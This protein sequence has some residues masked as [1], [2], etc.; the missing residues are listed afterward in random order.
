[1]PAT[2]I[3]ASILAVFASPQGG[4]PISVES[5]LD[6]V[7][8]YTDQAMAERVLQVTAT[9]PGAVTV[10]VGPLPM[11]ADRE[12]FQTRVQGASAVLQGLEVRQRT[13]ELQQS[14][15]DQ[16]RLQIAA[17]QADL[18]ALDAER[19]AIVAGQGMLE[20]VVNSVGKEGLTGY[21][22]MTL[23]N[24]FRFVTAETAKLDAREQIYERERDALQV[25]IRDLEQQLGGRVRAARPYQEVDLRLFFQQAGTAEVRLLYLVRGTS[26]EPV[27]DLRLSTDLTGVDVG[28]VGRI[29][30][31]TDEDWQ[32]VQV[33]LST[34][35]PQL[36]LDP[37]ELPRRWA[38]VYQ[39]ERW[40]R[41]AVTANAAPAADMAALESL[42]YLDAEGEV[43][44]KRGRDDFGGFV[45]APTVSVQD[46]GL[47]QQFAL[48]DRVSLK[49]GTEPRQFRLVDVPLEVRPERYIVPSLS[50][51]AYLRAEV[52]SEAEAPLLPGS[53]RVFLGPDY[54]GESSFP[55]LRQGDSTLLNLGIDP[56]L[57]VEYEV[58]LDE[59]DEPGLFSSELR[60]N[61][62]YEVRLKLSASARESI[63]VLIEEVLPVPQDD[64]IKISPYKMAAGAL[65]TP[66]DL[67]D[68][69]EKGVWRWRMTMR[70]GQETALRWGYTAAF[71]EKYTPVID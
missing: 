54:I 26:W 18:R 30:Q 6:R 8:V 63:D 67:K 61:H 49:S 59:R 14:E 32:D 12:S 7:T 29:Y 24:V 17:V 16:L 3:L 60:H 10:R 40:A 33:L 69:E 64:R 9:E 28:L 35:Q 1:M 5:Q 51:Q 25:Q 71:N 62:W 2:A 57:V 48:P 70:P 46:Y 52:T 13:G 11:T 65:D 42:G 22:G 43:A 4:E 36:G 27:Y 19:R 15:R 23:E 39:P 56:N 37:P 50:Q 45:A 68:R 44:D 47:S 31:Q 34:A 38:R 20:A 55:L 66:D 41:G 21:T 53:A 58:V